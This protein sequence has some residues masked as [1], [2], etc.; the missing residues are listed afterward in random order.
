AGS[1]HLIRQSLVESLVLST[2]AGG[3]GLLIA[4]WQGDVLQRISPIQIPYWIRFEMSPTIFA[5]AAALTL[6][7]GVGLGLLPALR[8]PTAQL[9]HVLADGGR[10]D[11]GT[12]ARDGWLRGALVVGEYALA[13][14]VLVG[15][16]LMVHAY[17]HLRRADNGFAIDERLTVRLSLPAGEEALPRALDVIER[18]MAA[19]ETMPEVRSVAAVSFLPIANE[20]Y[21]VARLE[22]EGQTYTEGQEPAALYQAVSEGYFDTLSIPLRAGRTFTASEVEEGRSVGVISSGLAERLWPG[23]DP[24]GRRVRATSGSPWLEIVG[25]VADIDPGEALAGI[26]QRPKVQLYV[27]LGT[28]PA[29]DLSQL[30]R[31]PALVVDS[32][33]AA[34]SLGPELR[35]RFASVAPDVPVFDVLPMS[36]VVRR[37]YF[38]QHIWSRMFAFLA[39]AALAIA[40]VGAYGVSTYA[41]S[42][43]R[44]EM[45]I[46]LALGARPD[47]LMV[48]VVSRGMLWAVAGLALGM[49]VA[50][51]MANAMTDLLHGVELADPGVLGSVVVLLAGVSLIASVVPAR[52]AARVDPVITLREG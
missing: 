36:E 27:P 46:R 44:R 50:V 22:V 1:G 38:A 17:E 6:G 37:H 7:T 41:V 21:R 45:G 29:G 26:D 32:A 35:R 18:G 12:S 47:R 16:L 10:S 25:V 19:I 34:A 20:G 49:V 24:R 2:L 11:G 31:V 42:R 30:G 52:R 40:A 15:A 39:F 4:A 48:A 3:L 13:V 33:A 28:S 43:R 9:S 5:F 8:R 51:P 14:I 23:E